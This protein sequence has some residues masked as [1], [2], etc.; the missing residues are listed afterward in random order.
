VPKLSSGVRKIEFRYGRESNEQNKRN[1]ENKCQETG[2]VKRGEKW[3]KRKKARSLWRT[4]EMEPSRPRAAVVIVVVAVLVWELTA[5]F[6]LNPLS[7]VYLSFSL[8]IL[9]SSNILASVSVPPYFFVFF[10]RL[11]L[12][13]IRSRWFFLSFPAASFLRL[14]ILLPPHGL[15]SRKARSRFL[16]SEV[17]IPINGL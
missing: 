13:F 1:R 16:S 6:L 15:A 10:S 4:F 7:L 9:S 8:F 12:A 11:I 14:R 3:E 2:T 5:D 17:G